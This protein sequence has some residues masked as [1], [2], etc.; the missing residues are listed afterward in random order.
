M[1]RFAETGFTPPAVVEIVKATGFPAA[2]CTVSIEF[3]RVV[4]IIDIPTI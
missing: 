2:F 1:T 4:F 3:G